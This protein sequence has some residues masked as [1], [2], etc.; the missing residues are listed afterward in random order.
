MS[1][2]S[3][4][5]P[6]LCWVWVGVAS[7]SF[8]FTD[9]ALAASSSAIRAYD[10]FA[11]AGKDYTAQNLEQAE[12]SNVKLE[13]ANFSRADLR[14]AVFN[15]VTLTNAQFRDADLTDSIAYLSDFT[16]ADLTNA[17]LNTAILLKS[18]FEDAT[19]TGADFTDATLE[20]SQVKALCQTAS[21]TNPITGVATRESLGCA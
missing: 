11:V 2:K 13:G 6:W 16:R 18:T 4:L 3:R 17:R 12:F 15:S 8:L 5:K 10:D 21:G 20:R 7:L 19:V 9:P 14:G 1:G